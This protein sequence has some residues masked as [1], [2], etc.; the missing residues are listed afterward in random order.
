MAMTLATLSFSAKGGYTAVTSA[1][2]PSLVWA[3]GDTLSVSAVG[4]SVAAFSG[5]VIAPSKL[6]GLTPPITAAVTRS[7]GWTISWTPDSRS[8][9]VVWLGVSAGGSIGEIECSVPDSVGTL[10]VASS[11]LTRFAAGSVY[12]VL[13]RYQTAMSSN[14]QVSVEAITNTQGSMMLQ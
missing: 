6:A 7:R 4:A 2:T 1:Q 8:G 12:V 3:P 13:E 10:T 5:S 14:G 9:E 11:L